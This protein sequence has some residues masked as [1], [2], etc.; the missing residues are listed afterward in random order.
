MRL[1]DVNGELTSDSVK[2]ASL[3]A[4]SLRKIHLT[5]EGPDFCDAMKAEVER[6]VQDC[7]GEY[8]PKYMVEPEMGDSDPLVDTVDV[9]E[10]AAA[11]RL[12]KGKSTPGEDGIPYSFLKRVPNCTLSTLADLF[13]ACVTFGYFPKAWKSA[14]GVML[15]KQGKDPKVVTN[16]RPISLLSTVGKLFEK[17][18]VRRMQLH[19][20][21]TNFFNKYQRAYLEKK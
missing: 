8:S 14:I 6:H 9:T 11:L 16:Y 7:S 1:E 2:V 12:C 18:I 20:G 15:P 10:V 4:E 21:A 19:F 5:H 13:T 3:F 17:V